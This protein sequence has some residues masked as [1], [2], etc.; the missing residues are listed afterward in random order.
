MNLAENLPKIFIISIVFAILIVSG[1]IHPVSAEIDNSRDT[2]VLVKCE[3]PGKVIEAGETVEYELTVTNTGLENNKKL[4]YESFDGTK[5]DW[6]IKFMDGTSQ[7]FKVSL[8]PNGSK[9]I[10]VVVETSSDTPVGEYAVRCHIGDGWYWV[11][12]RVSKCHAGEKG[13][14][15]LNVV[16]KEGEKVKGADIGMYINNGYV[17]SDKVISAA[18]GSVSTLTEPGTYTL[19]IS[20]PGYKNFEKK[21]VKI[22]GGIT[23]KVGTI[24]LEKSLYAADINVKS[25]VL[26]TNIGKKPAYELVLKNIGK[27]EDTFKFSSQ[28]FPQ[29]GYVRFKDSAT[30][31]TEISELYLKSGDEKTLTVEAIPPYGISPGDY[32]F[33]VNVD[34]SQTTY[35]ENLSLNIRGSYNLMVYS[36]QYRYEINKGN[37]ISFPLTL[38]NEGNA[39]VLTNVEV[40]VTAP[41][42]WQAEVTPQKIAAIQPGERARASI[43]IIPPVNIAASEY[44]ISVKVK[45]DQT[46]KSDDFRILIKEAPIIAG[47]GVLTL[48]LVIGGVYYM[49]RRYKRR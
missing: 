10:K 3:D 28:G 30:A 4:W 31:E 38:I 24:M 1:L 39:G 18:D 41:E 13:T 47:M 11:Y 26:T 29:G 5:Y 7:I 34:S 17:L 22:K 46:E 20:K 32:D 2:Y 42:G 14:L 49:F 9:Q 27:S 8:P 43:S 25:P 48:G 40:S 23:T 19:K 36:D 44:K 21:D 15:E 12:I 35:S 6:D 16:D 33:S 45:S 37:T